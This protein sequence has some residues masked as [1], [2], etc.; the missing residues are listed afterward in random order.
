MD[1]KPLISVIIPVYNTQQYLKQC[2]DSVINQTYKNLE[3]ILVDDGSSDDSPKI[4]DE[5]ALKDNRIKVIHKQNG[6]ESSARNAGLKIAKGCYIGFVDS[7]D[8]IAPDMYEFLYNLLLKNKADVSCCNMFEF[9]DG[10]YVPSVKLQ[11]EDLFEFNEVLSFKQGLY[12]WNRLYDRMLIGNAHFN[13]NFILCQDVDFN[14]NVLKNA[15]NIVFSKEPKY[16]YFNNGGSISRKKRFENGYIGAIE[17][18]DKL[19]EY[20]KK[21]NLKDALQTNK[22]KQFYWIIKFLFIVAQ[23]GCDKKES[24]DF[25]LRRVRKDIG[26]WFF[27]NYSIKTKLFLLLSCVNFNLSVKSYKLIL[28]LKTVV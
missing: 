7:D 1:N 23:T 2:I 22:W 18:Y 28:K 12:V 4:C 6:G 24:L 26:Y 8:F 21:N 5:H 13:E 3:I 17:I 16:Y 19:I 20:C 10:K 9:K 15:K 27:W 25:L 11:E 14:F